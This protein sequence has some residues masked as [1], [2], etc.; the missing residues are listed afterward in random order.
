[1]GR[2]EVTFEGLQP[3]A[4]AQE[5]LDPTAGQHVR[6]QARQLRRR[7]ARAHVDPDDAVALLGRVGNRAYLVLEVRFGGL[8]RHVDAGAGRVELP[9]VVD[10]AQPVFLVSS[11]EH[12]GAAVRAG[13][14][15]DADLAGRGPETDEVLT[16][17]A[18]T[19]RRAVRLRNLGGHQRRNPVL[20][21]EVAQE[22]AGPDLRQDVVVCLAEHAVESPLRD[23]LRVAALYYPA[24][25]G[26]RLYGHA[27]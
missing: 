22:R 6:L 18:Q 14:L 19:Y 12:R 2:V 5:L 24:P 8:R 11:E 1:M 10:A 9:A 15:D 4:V 27:T 25:T 7:H 21:H 20:A 17:E 26:V 16:Q 3:G 23:C 13:V